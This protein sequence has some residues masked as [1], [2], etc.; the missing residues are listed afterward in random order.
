ME[1]RLAIGAEALLGQGPESVTL[2][3]ARLGISRDTYYRY[4]RRM[5]DEGGV[6]GLLP[7]SRRPRSS[8]TAT[9]AQVMALIV[10]KHDELLAEG[11]DDG[12]QRAPGRRH[13]GGGAAV[14]G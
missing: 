9:S 1:V 3:C 6:Q 5:R 8:P 4:R 12:A 2:L 7:R 10:A 13:Q 11:W 14:P